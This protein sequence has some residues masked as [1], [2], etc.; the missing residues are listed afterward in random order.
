LSGT[1]FGE[2]ISLALVRCPSWAELKMRFVLDRLPV[3]AP[4]EAELDAQCTY[5]FVFRRLVQ[6]F[7]TFENSNIEGD[8]KVVVGVTAASLR[9]NLAGLATPLLVK[10]VLLL[11]GA[12]T[13]NNL[14]GDSRFGRLKDQRAG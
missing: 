11:V 14:D 6:V 12:E 10:I 8:A 9:D 4:F 7:C 3:A 1:Q 2:H 13:A 5:R